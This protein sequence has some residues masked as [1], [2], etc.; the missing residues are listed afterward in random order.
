MVL[1]D[2]E[3]GSRS[4]GLKHLLAGIVGCPISWGAPVGA[5]AAPVRG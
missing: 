2:S 5:S 1:S 3:E 4:T